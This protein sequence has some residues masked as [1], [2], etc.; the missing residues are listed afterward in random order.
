M[1]NQLFV[2]NK[3]FKLRRYFERSMKQEYNVIENMIIKQYK[4]YKVKTK[5]H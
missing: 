3:G 5:Y 4:Y 2:Q 1:Y